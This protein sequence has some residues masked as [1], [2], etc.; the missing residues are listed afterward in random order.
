MED[1][2]GATSAFFWTRPLPCRRRSEYPGKQG[3]FLGFQHC[4]NNSPL[5]MGC[6]LDAGVFSG[7]TEFFSTRSTQNADHI[8]PIQSLP[9][10]LH[11]IPGIRML[12][13]S[14]IEILFGPMPSISRMLMSAIMTSLPTNISPETSAAATS[15]TAGSAL[16]GVR[17]LCSPL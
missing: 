1:G 15:F 17:T 5:W 11:L 16:Y 13:K 4:K 9:F 12:K 8:P 3:W 7:L 10:P 14:G 6:H 2:F